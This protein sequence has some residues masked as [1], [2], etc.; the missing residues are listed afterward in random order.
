[1]SPAF[2]CDPQVDD[3]YSGEPLATIRGAVQSDGM[4]TAADVAVLWFSDKSGTCGGPEINCSGGGGGSVDAWECV[5]ACGPEP[6]ICNAEQ[7]VPYGACVQACGWEWFFNIDW[8]LCVDGAS[9]ERVSVSGEFPAAFTLNLYQPPPADALLQDA[10]GLRI[11]YGWF[12]VADPEVETIS[13]SLYDDAPPPAIIGGSGAHVLI[14]A[15]DPIP[16]DSDWGQYL[17]GAYDVGY[18]VVEVVP[19]V[20]CDDVEPIPGEGCFAT[21]DA[22]KP[23]AGDLATE[24]SVELTA[25][26]TIDWPGL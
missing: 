12:I 20:N 7:Q 19:G 3:E 5:Q 13:L 18:H 6:D 4:A 23:S 8:D 26:E 11:A 25:F 21:D 10:G 1:L 16:A 9:G 15:A 17:G 2:A 14:Y 22:Y 24:I